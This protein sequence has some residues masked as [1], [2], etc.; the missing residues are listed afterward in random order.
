MCTH[1]RYVTNRYTGRRLLVPCG[2]CEACLQSKANKMAQRIRN[3]I[4]DDEMAISVTLTYDEKF[5][6]YILRKDIEN[7]HCYEYPIYRDYK[8]RTFK[9]RPIVSRCINPIGSISAVDETTGEM[10][11]EN[12][13]FVP[14]LWKNGRGYNKEKM[15]VIFY[16]DVQ[17]FYK[18]LRENIAK[19]LGYYL[20]FKSF[21]CG[22][23]GEKK[24]RCHFHTLIVTKRENYELF[25]SAI[26]QSWRFADSDE[27][28]R[29]IE[30]ARN[31]ASYVAS[32]VNKSPSVPKILTALAPQK[33][34]CSKMFG[35][36]LSDFRLPKILE[37]ADKG[38]MCY[39]R[40]VKLQGVP[41]V[42]TVPVPKYVINRFFPQFKGLSRLTP[43][44]LDSLLRF[45]Y[46]YFRFHKNEY[47]TDYVD[48]PLPNQNFIKYE[49]VENLE[50]RS[51]SWRNYCA[52][53]N[54]I[55]Q[56]IETTGKTSYDYAIDYQRVWNCY[57]TTLYKHMFDNVTSHF[58]LYD[59]IN[60]FFDGHVRNDSLLQLVYGKTNLV[61]DC[62]Q[63]KDTKRITEYYTDIFRKKQNHK[64]TNSYIRSKYNVNF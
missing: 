33:H 45:P 55:K 42:L 27:L 10:F 16:K 39:N 62:N 3:S 56:Y 9:G 51:D 23:Y 60:E 6:P 47:L 13:S 41:T 32:Y 4:N 64:S 50:N 31:M 49:P 18:L 48:T 38:D 22:E 30:P 61:C 54:C 46:Q 2:R 25:R 34:S 43:N 59:N 1:K 17:N 19:R 52:L 58:E 20:P 63:F 12:Y 21:Q 28:R 14:N 15:G 37:K 24:H 40:L 35:V 44:T 11:K 8:F 29:S 7:P 26:M 57:K 53:K 5:V 36:T